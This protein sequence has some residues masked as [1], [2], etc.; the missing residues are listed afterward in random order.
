MECL[1]V[2]VMI[3]CPV[4]DDFYATLYRQGI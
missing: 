4:M 1:K 3:F 2:N